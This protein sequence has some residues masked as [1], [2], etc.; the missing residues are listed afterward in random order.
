MPTYH[1]FRM[2][3]PFQ[4]SIFLPVTFDAGDYTHGNVA[5]PRVDTIAARVRTESCLLRSRSST[6]KSPRRLT[7]TWQALL[8]NRPA[9]RH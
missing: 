3:V 9:R 5:L 7:H 1:V 4:D 8:P 6:P 2:Y